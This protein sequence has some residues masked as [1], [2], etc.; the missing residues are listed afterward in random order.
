MGELK[1]KMQ[2]HCQRAKQKATS[3]RLAV[4]MYKDVSD[5]PALSA[6]SAEPAES[7]SRT[8]N[9]EQGD[10]LWGLARK[11]R[12]RLSELIS[13]N[14]LTSDLI[15]PGQELLLPEP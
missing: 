1:S 5:Q 7:A 14:A 15:R 9:V 2:K 3:T 4:P 6:E 8:V 12:V 13:V 11:H 10:T